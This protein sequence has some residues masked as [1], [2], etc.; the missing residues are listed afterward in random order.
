MERWFE[1]R[2][3]NKVLDIAYRQMIV[4]LD[5]IN[6]L[7]KAIEAVAERNKETAKTIIARLFKTEEEV[8]DLRRVVFEEL[9]KGRL[10]PRDREDIMKLV[11]N[12]DKVADHV[13]DSARN[14][15]VLIDKDLPKEIWDAYHDMAHGIVSTAA[16]LRE[17]LK[18]LGEDNAR[19]REMS[20]RVEDEEN[21]VD[22]K[23]LEIKSLLLDYGDKLNPAT[24]MLLKDLL[25]SME[26]ATDRCADTGDYIRVLTVSFKK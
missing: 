23:Y 16:V 19:A 12:L 15:L 17:S 20:E 1:K 7:E 13:K 18:S 10:P 21:R 14:I 4:A 5:T 11:T 3:V 22:K 6:D 24:L 8:D 26:E 25:D 2:R 9:T